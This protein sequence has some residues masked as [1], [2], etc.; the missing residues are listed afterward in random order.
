MRG[1]AISSPTWTSDLC[2]VC[3]SASLGAV[4]DPF[5]TSA[6]APGIATPLWCQT[7]GNA[8]LLRPLY[9]FCRCRPLRLRRSGGENVQ[10]HPGLS[11][12]RSEEARPI[13]ADAPADHVR[14]LS[15]RLAVSTRRLIRLT[16]GVSA[17]RRWRR[18]FRRS[19]VSGVCR[20]KSREA[21]CGVLFVAEMGVK[22]Q[23]Q[24]GI[25]FV[26]SDAL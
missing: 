2:P 9:C 15:R 20:Q 6:H 1:D 25:P 11:E 12:P 19:E 17:G 5:G 3:P 23:H 26:C 14:S 4:F 8:G 13:G 21:D 24:T 22:R 7:R 16:L 10:Q 18:P